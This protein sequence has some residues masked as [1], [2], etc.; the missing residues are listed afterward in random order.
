M[1][2]EVKERFSDAELAEFKE[3]IQGKIAIVGQ[4]NAELGVIARGRNQVHRTGGKD[5][6]GHIHGIPGKTAH[7]N[8]FLEGWY[9]QVHIS[10]N[11]AHRKRCNRYCNILVATCGDGYIF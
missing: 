4:N 2:T 7:R 6:L 3:L 1:S 8:A 10:G 11:D 9:M 5:R